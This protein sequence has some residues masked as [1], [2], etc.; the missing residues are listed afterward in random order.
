MDIHVR[1]PTEPLVCAPVPFPGD[2][3]VIRTGFGIVGE[4]RVRSLVFYELLFG[5]YNN[6]RRKVRRGQRW[7]RKRHLGSYNLDLTSSEAGEGEIREGD[8]ERPRLLVVPHE[9]LIQESCRTGGAEI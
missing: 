3:Y 7:R 8:S 6:R 4:R 9:F 5:P 1:I 2:E